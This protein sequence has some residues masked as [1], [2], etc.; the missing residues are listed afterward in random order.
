MSALR[1]AGASLVQGGRTVLEGLDFAVPQG[2]F[3]GVLGANGAGKT[4]L[5]RAILGLVRPRAGRIEVLGRPARRGQTQVGYAPQARAALA[6]LRISGRALVAATA[7]GAAWGLPRLSATQRSDVDRVLALTES[8]D[9]AHRPVGALSGGE[10]QRLVL[11]QSLLGAPRLLLL[12]EPLASLDPHHQAATVALVRR[13]Q[14]QLGI[15]VLFSAH[16]LNPLLP[17][18]D[19]VLYLGGGRAALGT[20]GQVVTGPVL[21]RLYGAK[22][23]VVRAQDRIFVVAGQAEAGHVHV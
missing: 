14:R 5:I 16:D 4:T 12:D 8:A 22:M 9:Y 1:F 7:G 17:A 11:A 6:D 13:V 10:R 23:D 21:S 15:A 2:A 20:L 19:Q 18:L 3:V